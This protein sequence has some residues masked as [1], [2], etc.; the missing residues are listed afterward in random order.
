MRIAGIVAAAILASAP[1]ASAGW[2]VGG[3]AKGQF[4]FQLFDPNQIGAVL[5]GRKVYLGTGDFRV[6]TAAHWGDWDLTAQG[7]LLLLQ[8]NV[9]DAREDPSGG[10]YG[11]SWFPLPDSSD[12]RQALDLSW[13]LAEGGSHLVFGRMD[14]LSLGYAR[15]PLA[16]RLGRQALSWGNGLVFQVLDLFNPFPPYALD[17]EY[18]PGSDMLTTQ[19]LFSGGDDLQGIVVPRRADRSQPLAA[20][21]SSAALKWRHLQGSVQIELLAARHYRD[22][23]AG[24]GLSGNLAGGVWRLDLAESFTY[25][26]GAVTSLILNFDRSWV[27]AG[28]NLYGFVE[29]FRNGFGAT[30]FE[31]GVEGLDPRLRDR[32]VRGEVFSLGR[33]ELAGGFRLEWSPLTSL[34]PTVLVNPADPSAYLV[35]HLH[36]EWRENLLLDAGVQLGFGGRN[37]EYGGV[38]SSELGADLA[39]GRTFW[40]RVGYYF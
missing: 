23:V 12:A 29:Y 17:E 8:G 4:S 28:K 13:T 19:W 34:D 7:Q 39:P 30:S 37:T 32:L 22:D 26:G 11:S 38:P 2:E 31:G 9:L 18:K 20:R 14:R 1:S 24:L 40:A 33:D 25:G 21:E 36:H 3:H 15:G 35:L 6:N 5:V 10:S 16:I 27:W